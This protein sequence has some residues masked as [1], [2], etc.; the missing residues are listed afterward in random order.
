MPR[1]IG[2]EASRRTLKSSAGLAR[3]LESDQR[4]GMTWA[5]GPGGQRVGSSGSKGILRTQGKE[6]SRIG[7]ENGEP[8]WGS[9]TSARGG[10]V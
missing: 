10:Q 9:E 1:W 6:A 2:E 8:G 5:E 3:D 4:E 7:A